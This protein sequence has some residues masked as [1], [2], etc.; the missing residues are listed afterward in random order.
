MLNKEPAKIWDSNE[1]T[2]TILKL[3]NKVNQRDKRINDL[4]ENVS[5]KIVL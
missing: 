2:D 1:L 4:S 5:Q 3:E